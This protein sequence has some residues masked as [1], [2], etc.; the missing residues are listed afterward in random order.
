MWVQQAESWMYARLVFGVSLMMVLGTGVACARSSQ[1][2]NRSSANVGEVRVQVTGLQSDRGVL[3]IG[4][5]N[6]TVA[7]RKGVD[8][9]RHAVIPVERDVCEWVIPDVPHG[10]YAISLYHDENG[11]AALDRNGLGIP[12]EPYGFS[13]N[14]KPKM[15]MPPYSAVQFAVASETVTLTVTMQ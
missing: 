15:G 5:Y 6:D 8:S 14:A 2:A 13:N 9:F 12:T 10:T 11:N 3:R 1:P 7:Y 4:L